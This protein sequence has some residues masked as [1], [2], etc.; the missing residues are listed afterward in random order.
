MSKRT[1]AQ[2]RSVVGVSY[3]ILHNAD[4][5]RETR[6]LRPELV[7]LTRLN[8]QAYNRMER[9][10]ID[11]QCNNSGSPEESLERG[12][13]MHKRAVMLCM[14]LMVTGALWAQELPGA[15]ASYY[16]DWNF[17]ASNSTWRQRE[18]LWSSY[19]G[20]VT[21]ELSGIDQQII[22]KMDRVFRATETPKV[23]MPM[24][25]AGTEPPVSPEILVPFGH[26]VQG[27]REI[28]VQVRVMQSPVGEPADGPDST[29]SSGHLPNAKSM[30]QFT[31]RWINRDGSW[32]VIRSPF[33]WVEAQ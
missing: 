17:V 9:S 26:V 29:S 31:D 33:V 1:G 8:A 7:S 21:R 16:D 2:K 24:L 18:L 4:S 3:S 25:L 6:A 27:N 5:V 28:I 30:C 14:L 10:F 15:I 32:R 12:H 23:V 13:F 20:N 11:V 19:R 22:V